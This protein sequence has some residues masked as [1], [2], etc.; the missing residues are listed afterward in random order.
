MR[1]YWL[2]GHLDKSPVF[3]QW[4]NCMSQFVTVEGRIQDRPWPLLYPTEMERSEMPCMYLEWLL[5]EEALGY[6]ISPP[7]RI[8]I[9][10]LIRL[11]L[12]E[13]H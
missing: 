11:A 8:R 3:T 2:T 5:G 9:P 1:I 6:L 12:H 13:S 4:T 10:A 7:V